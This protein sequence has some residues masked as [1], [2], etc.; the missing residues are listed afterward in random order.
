MKLLSKIAV[1]FATT[2]AYLGLAKGGIVTLS[3]IEESLQVRNQ[4][5][6]ALPALRQVAAT[7]NKI[8]QTD[9]NEFQTFE[10]DYTRI[11]NEYALTL[12]Q[13]KFGDYRRAVELSEKALSSKSFSSENVRLAFVKIKFEALRLNGDLPAAARYCGNELNQFLNPAIQKAVDLLSLSCA[14]TIVKAARAQFSSID[15][16]SSAEID[17]YVYSLWNKRLELNRTERQLLFASL[18]GQ[19]KRYDEAMALLT[20]EVGTTRLNDPVLAKAYLMLGE[21]FAAQGDFASAKDILAYLGK[22]SRKSR[23]VE[24]E[25][26]VDTSTRSLAL[27]SLARLLR[28]HSDVASASEVY[29]AALLTPALSEDVDT[30]LESAV[31]LYTLGQTEKSLSRFSK[32]K[33]TLLQTRGDNTNFGIAEYIEV[34]SKHDSSQSQSLAS[35]QVAFATQDLTYLINV[36]NRLSEMG[37]S[38]LIRSGRAIATL[39]NVYQSHTSFSERLALFAEVIDKS[40]SEIRFQRLDTLELLQIA[41][42]TEDVFSRKERGQLSTLF[43]QF[44]ELKNVYDSLNRMSLSEW[45]LTERNNQNYTDYLSSLDRKMMSIFEDEFAK[46]VFNRRHANSNGAFWKNVEK[47][48]LA[49]EE[50]RKLFIKLESARVAREL[51]KLKRSDDELMLRN[52]LQKQNVEMADLFRE[53]ALFRLQTKNVLS[54]EDNAYSRSRMKLALTTVN[55]FKGLHKKALSRNKS[56]NPSIEKRILAAWDN[57]ARLLAGLDKEFVVAL[58][59]IDAKKKRVVEEALA[60]IRAQDLQERDLDFVKKRLADQYKAMLPAIIESVKSNA[61]I[62]RGRLTI[63]ANTGLRA[64][65]EQE[66]KNVERSLDDADV[67]ELWLKSLEASVDDGL[68]R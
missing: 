28:D 55:E 56:I 29:E 18:F 44:A 31:V 65:F 4:N 45:N 23:L 38:E 41:L 66:K 50:N 8:Y 26:D 57:M 51:R 46:E 1:F 52:E 16:L 3:D 67:R 33:D 12:R 5:V 63:A 32:I 25:I 10:S 49:L 39:Q 13:L 58:D 7:K 48:K 24:R 53:L 30:I 61:E 40:A 14:Q 47:A 27:L 36:K 6:E 21:L 9:A 68:L 64:Q 17:S 54:S 35:T 37:H 62:Y 20:Q 19:Y 59:S 15:A 2:S 34:L 43:R 11:N 22:L 42:Q 60:A